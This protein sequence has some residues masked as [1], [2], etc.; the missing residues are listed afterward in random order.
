MAEKRPDADSFKHPALLYIEKNNMTRK[1]AAKAL[2]IPKK[3]GQLNHVL[4]R[5][6]GTTDT[7]KQLFHDVFGIP[8][9]QL[10]NIPVRPDGKAFKKL[11]KDKK[12]GK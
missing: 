7:W 12:K 1:E 5:W 9:D 3:L 6:R 8:M 10:V 2:G 11:Q 4:D